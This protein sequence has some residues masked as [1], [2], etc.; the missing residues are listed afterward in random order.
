MLK[1]GNFRLSIGCLLLL[2]NSCYRLNREEDLTLV[3]INIIDRNGLNET[4]TN[5]ERLKS[6]KNTNFLNPQPYQKVLR[7]Y[8]TKLTDASHSYITSYYENGQLKQYLEV[9]NNRAFGTYQE[10]Y[11]DG[12]L[13]L[14]VNVIGGIAD[15][16]SSAEK[17]WQFDESARAWDENG[18]IQTEINYEKG[19]LEGDSYYFHP[20]GNIWKKIAYHKN[21]VHGTSIY[22]LENGQVLQT[23]HFYQGLRHGPSIRFWS[24]EKIAS[25]EY[26]DYGLLMEGRYFDAQNQLI[27]EISQGEGTRIIFSKETIYEKQQIHQGI[28]KGKVEVFNAKGDLVRL[29]HI[30]NQEKQGEEI[31]YNNAS[32]T[33]ALPSLLITWYKGKIQGPVKTWYDNGNIESQR[34]MINNK[35]NGIAMAWYRD[36]NLML[37]E[38]Y[39]YNLLKKG[40]Y[41]KKG[42]LMPISEIVQGKGVATIYDGEGLFIRRIK[43]FNGKPQE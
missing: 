32:A 24:A 36:G 37:V 30:E 10:W 19:L 20:N 17:S 16:T 40:E 8:Q 1:L 15:L 33:K 38:E 42:E 35:C 28:V 22:Y 2:A 25:D 39:D 4:I 29:Y 13:K 9:V 21:K 23:I 5:K 41:Y 14:K 11:E 31:E 27:G 6:Y 26:F 34:E 18:K 43:Y 12:I 7:N 3:S